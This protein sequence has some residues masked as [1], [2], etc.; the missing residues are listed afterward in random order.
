MSD[1]ALLF[2]IRMSG[3]EVQTLVHLL[4]SAFSEI[5]V[6]ALADPH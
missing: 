1:D 3:E 6:L 2:Y 4:A 5:K